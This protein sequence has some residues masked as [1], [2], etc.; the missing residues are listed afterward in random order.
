MRPYLK[1]HSEG[2][3][4]IPAVVSALEESNEISSEESVLLTILSWW[5]E[6]DSREFG[7]E[8]ELSQRY[9]RAD[10]GFNLCR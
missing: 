6:G 8:A 9:E 4:I 7:S 2:E 1:L 5:Y 3:K 10:Y